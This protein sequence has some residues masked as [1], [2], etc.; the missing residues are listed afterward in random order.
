MIGLFSRGPGNKKERFFKEPLSQPESRLVENGC[1][2][3]ARCRI[4][5]DH[6]VVGDRIVAVRIHRNENQSQYILVNLIEFDDGRWS[7]QIEY[8]NASLQEL[9]SLIN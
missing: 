5:T 9:N 2:E 3:C 7:A 6:I 1:L 4:I 8:N